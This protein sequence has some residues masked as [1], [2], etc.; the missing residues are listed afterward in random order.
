MFGNVSRFKN[1]LI[2]FSRLNGLW[3][4]FFWFLWK[5]N[6]K[7]YNVRII[8]KTMARSEKKKTNK[9]V[10][11]FDLTYANQIWEKKL[12]RLT[13]LIGW[14]I[15]LSYEC[16][17]VV[18]MN[19]SAVLLVIMI[20]WRICLFIKPHR[21]FFFRNFLVRKFTGLVKHWSGHISLTFGSTVI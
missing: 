1:L 16:C 13:P 11:K 9:F 6:E 3:L 7:S 10:I 12:K 5:T 8:S 2:C 19:V 20:S 17:S 4:L 21:L 18:G 14:P 15:L